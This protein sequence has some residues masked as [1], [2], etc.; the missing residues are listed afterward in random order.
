[1][2]RAILFCGDGHLGRSFSAARCLWR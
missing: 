2:L 1:V